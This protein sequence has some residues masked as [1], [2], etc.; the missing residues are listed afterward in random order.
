MKFKLVNKIALMMFATTLVFSTLAPKAYAL[1]VFYQSEFFQAMSVIKAEKK[2]V[3]RAISHGEMAPLL[4]KALDALVSAG[5]QKLRENNFEASA[6]QFENEWIRFYSSSFGGFSPL[7]LGDHKPVFEWLADF[8]NTL[9]SKLGKDL[10]AYAHLDDIKAINFGAPVAIF[11]N[12]D[13]RTDDK[14]DV[15][16]YRKHFVPFTTAILY[17]SMS[18]A[19][20]VTLSTIPSFVCSSVAEIPRGGYELFIAPYL[21][22][23]IYNR[24]NNADLRLQDFDLR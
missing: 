21:S 12:G 10:C 4:Q 20:N 23:F 8:Y 15:V 6:A 18:I 3:I 13:P 9:E 14:Y 2:R 24:T 5:N 16:E 22:D 1:D 11:P 17:W 7:D 19:C